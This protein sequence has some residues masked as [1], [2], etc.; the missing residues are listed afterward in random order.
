MPPTRIRGKEKKRKVAVFQRGGE[1]VDQ[2]EKDLSLGG[3]KTR[4]RGKRGPEWEGL[5]F[6]KKLKEPLG[7]KTKGLKTKGDVFRNLKGR[8]QK[9]ERAHR[10]HKDHIFKNIKEYDFYRTE[11]IWKGGLW[12]GATEKLRGRQRSQGFDV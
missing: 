8:D 7:K 6:S 5:S 2:L 9:T 12:G 11:K 3:R 1:M 4:N 10:E